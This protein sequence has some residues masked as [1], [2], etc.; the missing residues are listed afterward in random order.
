M[1]DTTEVK[2]SVVVEVGEDL[3]T[4]TVVRFCGPDLSAVEP[5]IVWLAT[6]PAL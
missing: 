5:H 4:N 3:G 2:R 6:L 1:L